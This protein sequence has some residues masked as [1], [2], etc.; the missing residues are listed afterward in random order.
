ME[1]CEKIVTPFK[2]VVTDTDRSAIL[3]F[4]ILSPIVCEIN[5]DFCKKK[6]HSLYLTPPLRVPLEIL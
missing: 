5:G 6:S 1:I 2:V 3:L 4:Y